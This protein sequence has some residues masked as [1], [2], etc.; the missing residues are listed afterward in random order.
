MAIFFGSVTRLIY[1][2]KYPL[3]K[4]NNK[5]TRKSKSTENSI[6]LTVSSFSLKIKLSK[7]KE[8]GLTYR[9]QRKENI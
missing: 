7:L 2:S 9:V 6:N 3:M 4:F 8:K 5:S 1:P